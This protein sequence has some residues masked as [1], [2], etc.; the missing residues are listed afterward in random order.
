MEQ[1]GADA[2]YDASRDP[3]AKLNGKPV[4]DQLTFDDT[5]FYLKIWGAIFAGI[6]SI[7]LYV[8]VSYLRS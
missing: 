3:W 4:P 7:F 1:V 2:R 8:A 6:F 5:A